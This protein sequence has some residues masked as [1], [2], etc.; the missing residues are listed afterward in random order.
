MWGVVFF[1]R[2]QVDVMMNG[3]GVNV[4]WGGGR[5]HHRQDKGEH[6]PGACSMVSK[7]KVLAPGHSADSSDTRDAAG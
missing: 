2:R 1:L 4:V 7:C 5:S 3:L 6:F